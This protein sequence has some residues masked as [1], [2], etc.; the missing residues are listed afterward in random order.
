MNCGHCVMAVKKELSKI[1]N[2]TVNN[3]EIGK[4]DVTYDESLVTDE[5]IYSA[6]DEAGFKVIQ[7]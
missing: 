7:K 3:V 5:I 2:L 1:D 6:I 4:A